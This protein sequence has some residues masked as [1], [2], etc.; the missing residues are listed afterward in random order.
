MPAKE[1]EFG[2]GSAA[3]GLHFLTVK[4]QQ[5]PRP[6]AEPQ[7]QGRE[8][9]SLVDGSFLLFLW[10]LALIHLKLNRII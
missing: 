8:T 5:V 3:A 9:T 6:H 1:S 2:F 7:V 4:G 10:T